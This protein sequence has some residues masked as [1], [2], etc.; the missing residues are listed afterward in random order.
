M[1]LPDDYQYEDSKPKSKVTPHP[2]FG[3]LVGGKSDASLRQ[4]YAE[5]LTSPANPRFPTVV[6]NRYWRRMMGVGLIEPVDDM[7]DGVEASHPDGSL[8][9]RRACHPQA[10]STRPPSFVSNNGWQRLSETGGSRVKSTIRRR[11]AARKRRIYH[12][13]N[14]QTL[15]EV[16][17][18]IL[19]LN[20]HTDNHRATS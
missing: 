15:D 16:L 5:W 7:R 3:H 20:P 1:K 19:V 17:L 2:M 13:L 9:H 4:A 12:Q 8:P 10:R 6:A 18:W 14:D 11:P